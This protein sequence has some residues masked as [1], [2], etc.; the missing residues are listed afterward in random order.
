[1]NYLQS[2]RSV[3]RE[4]YKEE[5]KGT[6]DN[7]FMHPLTYVLTLDDHNTL[8]ENQFG[9]RPRDVSIT[10]NLINHLPLSSCYTTLGGR[11]REEVWVDGGLR[12]SSVR[13]PPVGVCNKRS[14]R[15][16]YRIGSLVYQFRLCLI[17]LNFLCEKVSMT[18]SLRPFLWGARVTL[19]PK[20]PVT[21]PM[22]LMPHHPPCSPYK[23]PVPP[24]RYVEQ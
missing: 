12:S 10:C 13:R 23:R 8:S 1:M 9:W 5:R 7:N 16:L 18:S 4:G 22:F 6:G 3:R 20:W 17:N 21:S 19:T 15:S 24:H 14:T 2:M 11:V